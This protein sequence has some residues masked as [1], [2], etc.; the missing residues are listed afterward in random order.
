MKQDLY[1]VLKTGNKHLL[2]QDLYDST[3]GN[4]Q[5]EQSALL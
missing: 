2:K 3:R 1:D 5:I 4:P